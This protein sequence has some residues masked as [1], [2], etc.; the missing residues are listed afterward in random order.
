MLEKDS[1]EATSL[2]AEGL[3]FSALPENS[4]ISLLS[5]ALL[6]SFLHHACELEM[7]N[8]VSSIDVFLKIHA[9]MDN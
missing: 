3:P 1:H 7:Q 5:F 2:K 6:C 4:N 8:N 9:I